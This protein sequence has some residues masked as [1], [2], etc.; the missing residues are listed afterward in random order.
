MQTNYSTQGAR[1]GVLKGQIR[2]PSPSVISP[3]PACLLNCC[4]PSA[5]AQRYQLQQVCC[6]HLR[7]QE[8]C[9]QPVACHCCC[10][11]FLLLALLSCWLAPNGTPPAAEPEH[12]TTQ[13]GTGHDSMRQHRV[14]VCWL[15]ATATATA[16]WGGVEWC[17]CM[18]LRGSYTNGLGPVVSR[19]GIGLARRTA[20]CIHM[21]QSGVA[22]IIKSSS[23]ATP[24]NYVSLA[25]QYTNNLRD[26]PLTP[27]QTYWL[28][29]GWCVVLSAAMLPATS[30]PPAA[31]PPVTGSVAG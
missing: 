1:K 23:I 16:G 2:W 25:P 20:Y 22:G 5:A 30:A 26:P 9:C 10:L 6:C 7:L 29:V 27:S 18:Q 13:H 3:L 28:P 4:R 17:L 15:P 19:S 31:L 12:S 11:V 14:D 24:S 8:L 21:V